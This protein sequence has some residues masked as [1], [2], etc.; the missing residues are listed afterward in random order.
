[1]MA[2]KSAGLA[3]ASMS[4]QYMRHLS[5]EENII[6]V[7]VCTIPRHNCQQKSLKANPPIGSIEI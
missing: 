4:K 2:A 6:S 3:R 5:Q 7:L 1:M